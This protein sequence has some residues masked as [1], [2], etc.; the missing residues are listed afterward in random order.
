MCSVLKRKINTLKVN[1]CHGMA[2]NASA[3]HWLK[4][5]SRKRNIA[6]PARPCKGTI[7]GNPLR[8]TTQNS[9]SF[10]YN[11]FS[12]VNRT[13]LPTQMNNFKRITI[14]WIFTLTGLQFLKI[15]RIASTS[16]KTPKCKKRNTYLLR[17]SCLT[18]SAE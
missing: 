18:L 13:K 3:K 4:M 5:S 11:V 6:L 10:F 7:V 17:Y 9:S 16:V 8:T 14:E 15:K 12:F 2:D 1:V